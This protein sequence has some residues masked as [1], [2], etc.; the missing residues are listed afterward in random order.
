MM[1]DDNWGREGGKE[2]GDK[3]RLILGKGS[4][5]PS[6]AYSSTSG[7]TDYRYSD[8]GGGRTF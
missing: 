2:E 3:E 6:Q 1:N 8:A 5:Q 7:I 4:G